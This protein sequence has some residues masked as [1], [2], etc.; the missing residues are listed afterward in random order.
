M[1]GKSVLAERFL[2]VLD[3]LDGEHAADEHEADE[4][5][6]RAGDHQAEAAAD[7]D[8]AEQPVHLAQHEALQTRSNAEDTEKRRR[9]G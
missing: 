3:V 8:E 7:A 5:G 4:V 2:L 1:I 6:E 9:S